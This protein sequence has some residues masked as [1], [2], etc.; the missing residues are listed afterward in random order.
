MILKYFR[1]SIIILCFVLLTSCTISDSGN[2][3]DPGGSKVVKKTMGTA[4]L[5]SIQY[6]NAGRA[7]STLVQIDGKSYLI[8][9]GEE[10]SVPA[11]F[12]AL[13]DRGIEKLE[14]VFLTHTHSDH[15]GG[16]TAISLK[17]KVDILYSAEISED[18]KN[19]DNRIEELARDLDL[20]H[21]KLK[22][23]ERVKLADNAYF[24]VIAPLVYNSADD[25]DNSLVLRLNV[26]GKT[27]LFVG[28]MQF[29]EEETLLR[30]GVDLKADV[31]KVGNHGNPDSTS[32]K[33][34]KAVSPEIAVI[35]TD[36][37]VDE[38]SANS[39]VKDLLSM[40]K[41]YVTQDFELGV[42]L[43]ISKNGV[44]KVSDPKKSREESMVEITEASKE[45]QT[46][47]IV[48]KGESLDISGYYIYSTKGAEVFIFP[49]GSILPAS[50]ILTVGGSGV[51]A[52]FNWDK[53]T[54]WNK[55]NEDIAQLYDNKGN[56]LTSLAS[57]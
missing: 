51:Q 27:F 2:T 50:G 52:D 54:V 48:N 30:A 46:V 24:E 22:A 28:D 47:T 12:S 53:K 41:V 57:E 44:I 11:I 6:I 40:A 1:I 45:T 20:Q 34:A 38:D 36:T 7:D 3:N 8:D 14:G 32:A 15:V 4:E 31:L 55:K 26:N 16:T 29:A 42:L 37:S 39:R 13:A 18:K 25:N 23:G 10:S 9:T 43:E 17:Y 5:V 56:L 21:R 19:G 49:E 35:P 33:F